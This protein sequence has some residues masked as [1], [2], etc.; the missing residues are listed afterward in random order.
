MTDPSGKS[1]GAIHHWRLPLILALI[2]IFLALPAVLSGWM[3]DD[4]F[5][6]TPLYETDAPLGYYDFMAQF[7]EAHLHPWWTSPDYQLRFFRPLA[8]LSIHLDFL[9]GGGAP[10]F[11]HLDSLMW[12]LVM[13]FGGFA[14]FRQILHE[15]RTRKWAMIIFTLSV[16]HTWAAGWVA[17]RHS[18]MSGAFTVWAAAIYLRWRVNHHPRHGV[19]PAV[20]FA[21]GLLCGE[22]AL[23]LVLFVTCYEFAGSSDPWRSRL[24][25]LLPIAAIACLYVVAYSA[26]GFGARGSGAYIHPFLYPGDYFA[27]LVPKMLAVTGAFG[28]G[29]PAILRPIPQI[30]G[31]T[32]IAG[33]ITVLLLCVALLRVGRFSDIQRSHLLRW[34]LLAIFFPQL[35]ALSGL[36][37]G[38]EFIL[39]QIAFSGVIALVL[40]PLFVRADKWPGTL[41]SRGIASLLLLGALGINP[42]LRAAQS[43]FIYM[44][45]VA[46]ADAGRHAS[47]E[48]APNAPV[49]VINGDFMRSVGFPFAV[50]RH[51]QR[52][53]PAWQ[54]L[55]TPESDIVVE[56]LG[57][58][59]FKV[60][61]TDN[62]PLINDF[63]HLY[64]RPTNG[65]TAGSRFQFPYLQAEVLAANES[66]PTVVTYDIP[67]LAN[68]DGICL[69][70][71]RDGTLTTWTP[72]SVGQST[73]VKFVP[74]F[75]Q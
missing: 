70:Q 1:T 50:A 7:K 46:M 37:Q 11:A 32:W 15:D 64:R 38:R 54:H 69:L 13:L 33:I 27:L 30:G 23:A 65:L 63:L 21:L 16:C 72:P 34:L 12:S 22:T 41:I 52:I 24:R 58:T 53:F 4:Y 18:V 29:I 28:F 60:N 42:L 51:Q 19:A 14:I 31:L 6:D 25:R 73:T 74:P 5:F 2:H 48:C 49:Y 47:L 71:Y 20:L 17:A 56:R 45:S 43:G 39:S 75:Q 35:P 36:A 8:S 3:N 57:Q 67:A 61:S 40:P 59:L 9:V 26:M 66:G 44:S 55:N 62:S 10:L 68:P